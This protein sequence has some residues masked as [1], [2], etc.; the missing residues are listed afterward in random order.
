MY[1]YCIVNKKA[2]AVVVDFPRKDSFQLE[3]LPNKS[4]NLDFSTLSWSQI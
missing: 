2:A 4:L 1:T 3:P